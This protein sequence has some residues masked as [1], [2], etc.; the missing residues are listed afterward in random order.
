MRQRLER[1]V[2]CLTSL[3]EQQTSTG[4]S[5]EVTAEKHR[6]TCRWIPCSHGVLWEEGSV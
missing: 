3:G 5:Q 1:T 4:N 2:R 6:A